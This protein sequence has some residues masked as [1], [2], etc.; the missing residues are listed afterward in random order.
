M[1]LEKLRR[2]NV[3]HTGSNNNMIMCT[4]KKLL[5]N[6]ATRLSWQLASNSKGIPTWKTVSVQLW[7]TFNSNGIGERI[8]KDTYIVAC[9]HGMNQR[10]PFVKTIVIPG[11][12]TTDSSIRT[13]PQTWKDASHVEE[14]GSQVT[15]VSV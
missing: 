2:F 8:A 10:P 11:E 9:I 7:A 3:K 14:Y 4:A 12:G 1:L 5:R 6:L 13:G 15:A